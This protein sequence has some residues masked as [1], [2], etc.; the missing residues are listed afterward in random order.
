MGGITGGG[1]DAGGG[2]R[3]DALDAGDELAR[4]MGVEQVLDV[5]LISAR[6][7]RQVSRSWQ[8]WRAWS[9]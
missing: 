5:V 1:D 9:L 2:L 6:R 3:A 4:D 7:L 8:R